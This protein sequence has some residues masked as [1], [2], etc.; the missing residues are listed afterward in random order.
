MKL[1]LSVAIGLLIAWLII[2][3]IDKETYVL[4][5]VTYERANVLDADAD[6]RRVIRA[7]AAASGRQISDAD[8][9]LILAAAAPPPT[10]AI[11]LP[12]T[13]LPPA[14]VQITPPTTGQ[15]PPGMGAEAQQAAQAAAAAVVSD[16]S[17]LPGGGMASGMGGGPMGGT[18]TITA[19]GAP[20]GAGQVAQPI[21]ADAAALVPAP[22]AR[23]PAPAARAPAPRGP[24]TRKEVL[25]EEIDFILTKI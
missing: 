13:A 15:A 5:P 14:A 22:R 8:A 23:A 12:G 25:L 17:G 11:R 1:L 4:A 18:T 9:N 6:E 10:P 19:G 3:L 16:A 21:T 2:S 24:K 20:F 7:V